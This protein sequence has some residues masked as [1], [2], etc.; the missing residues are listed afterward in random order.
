MLEINCN[1][2]LGHRGWILFIISQC[3]T[4]NLL[5]FRKILLGEMSSYRK[6]S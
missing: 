4:C 3:I 6:Y 2:Y 1:V 5:T